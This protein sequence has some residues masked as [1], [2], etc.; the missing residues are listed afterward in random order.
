MWAKY[1]RWMQFETLEKPNPLLSIHTKP[2]CDQQN[3]VEVPTLH[4]A[5]FRALQAA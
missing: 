1:G 2:E 5:L 4:P 3:N